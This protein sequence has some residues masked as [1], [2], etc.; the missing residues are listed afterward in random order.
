MMKTIII[1]IILIETLFLGFYLGQTNYL[2]K[3]IK[4]QDKCIS[5]VL[6]KDINL[7]EFY[8]QKIEFNSIFIHAEAAVALRYQNCM[9]G[10]DDE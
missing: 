7:Q 5:H 1:L 6:E 9:F 8:G 3:Q 4:K 10:R 2:K